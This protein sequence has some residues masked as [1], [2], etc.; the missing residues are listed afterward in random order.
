MMED[1]ARD[2]FLMQ[3]ADDGEHIQW[4][5]SHECKITV[6]LVDVESKT[7]VAVVL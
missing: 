4:C 2:G 5:F 1:K 6:I 7:C 3:T